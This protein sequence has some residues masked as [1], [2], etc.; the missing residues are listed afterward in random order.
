VLEAQCGRAVTIPIRNLYYLF[1]YAWERFPEGG[2]TEVGIDECPDLPNLFARVL[3]NGVNR[4]L[5]RG[6]D[7]GYIALEEEMRSPRGR[8]LIDRVIKEQTL[9]RGTVDCQIDELQHDVLHNQ[10]IKATALA[11]AREPS[12]SPV[13]SHQ[14]RNIGRRLSDVSDVRLTPGLFRRVQLFRNSAQY[15]Q[16]MRLCEFV[17]R[18]LMPETGGAGGRFADILQDEARMS[19]IFE[20]FLRNF[21]FYEQEVYAVAREEMR[22]RM[23][24][25]PGGEAGL[26]PVMR[27]D[28]TLRSK[29]ST[30]V[31]DAKFYA[32]PFPRSAGVP[33][34]RSGHLYQLFAYMKHAGDRGPSQPVR[35]ALV[36]ASPGESSCQRYRMDGHDIAI[37]AV[38]LSQPWPMIHVE[39]L[40]LLRG[41]D[42][43]DATYPASLSTVR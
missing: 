29:T 1:C 4:L 34:L 23:D 37:A 17:C 30:I 42:A 8:I 40:A 10:I 41:F 12:V 28:V 25:S 18:S 38:D 27:T 11:L 2:S 31:M 7:R 15:A 32:E 9:L 36:Y 43:Q 16:L 3:V 35:G 13:L 33:K 14:L 19:Q 39:L 6:L 26:I 21:Y 24:P 22:W 20:D 5:R